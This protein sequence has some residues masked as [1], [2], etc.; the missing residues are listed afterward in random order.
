M[1]TNQ[2]KMKKK[3]LIFKIRAS[4]A[5]NIM[6]NGKGGNPSVGAQTYCQNWVKEHKY[7]RPSFFTS[8][9]TEKGNRVEEL[10]LNLIVET[11]KLGMIYKNE[12]RKEDDF[13]TGEM[14]FMHEETIFDN[15]SSFSLDTFPM[16]E[17]KLDT[18]YERQ[19]KVYLDLW[20]LKKGK[21]CYT[22]IDTPK[23]LLINEIKWLNSDDEKQDVALKHV[24]TPDL[25][26]E[27]K[28]E[29]FPN[30]KDIEFIE[31]PLI[32]RIRVFEVENDPAFIIDLHNKVSICRKYIKEVLWPEI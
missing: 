9:Y 30:A 7:G 3:N 26:S 17:T 5:T 6:A 11:L 27:Y 28:Q 23:D 21:V 2:Q 10:G 22:L 24:F 20:K 1:A 19:M 4:Q 31:I 16:F 18:I 8:K 14:D 32:D 13:K 12:E 25:W 29:L 15:K